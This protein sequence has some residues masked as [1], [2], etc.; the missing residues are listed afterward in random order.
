PAS[1]RNADDFASLRFSTL[2]YL[3]LA[4]KQFF[5][6]ISQPGAPVWNLMPGD[7][8]SIYREVA[9]NIES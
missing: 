2:A 8:C 1:A 7:K 9:Q 6:V 4:V 5:G 3:F